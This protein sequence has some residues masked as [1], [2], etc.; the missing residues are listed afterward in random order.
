MLCELL[1]TAWVPLSDLLLSVTTLL[2]FISRLTTFDWLPVLAPDT[3][4]FLR[5]SVTVPFEPVVA[6]LVVVVAVRADV[7]VVRRAEFSPYITPDPVERRCPY[8]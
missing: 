1:L 4:L 6:L 7:L 3:E 5:E 8:L 2:L